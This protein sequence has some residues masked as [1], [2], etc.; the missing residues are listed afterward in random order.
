MRSIRLSE[1][2]PGVSLPGGSDT[3]GSSPRRTA[4][5]GQ[6]SSSPGRGVVAFHPVAPVMQRAGV[7]DQLAGKLDPAQQI[8]AAAIKG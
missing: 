7:P 6:A 8:L 2:A 5:P 3:V 4:G 1:P